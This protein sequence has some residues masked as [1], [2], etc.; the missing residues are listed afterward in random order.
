MKVTQEKLPASQIGLEIEISAEASQKAYEKIVKELARTTNLPGFR[1]GK[2]PRQVLI[3]RLGAQRVKA[4]ALEEIVQKSLEE[5]IEQESLEI[6]GNHQLRTSFEEL[7]ERYKPGEPLTFSASVDV[8][9]SL[10]LGEE[11]QNLSVKAEETTYDSAQVEDFIEQR[12]KEQ[13]TL[14]PVEER[15]AQMGD[16]VV[17]D[18]QGKYG[19]DVEGKEAGAEIPSTAAQDFQV[20]LEEGRFIPG[21]VEGIVGMTA[22]ESKDLNLTFPE[23]Y[24]QEE[25][26]GV[27][28]VFNIKLKEIKEKELPEID[29]DFAQEVSEFETMAELRESLESQFK[30]KAA[31]DTKN[32]IHQVIIEQLLEKLGEAIEI[33]ETM[34]Q[35]EVDAMLTQSAMQM[36]QMGID[37]RQ[38]FTKD[39]IPQMRERSRPEATNRLK[40]KLILREINKKEAIEVPQNEIDAKVKEIRE[41][42]QERDLDLARLKAMVV[43]DLRE[44][45]T[46]DWLQE[47]ANV[48]LVPKGS[49]KT[50]EAEETEQTAPETIETTAQEVSEPETPPSQQ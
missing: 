1:K 30:E 34:V 22:E 15:P 19:P 41:Q 24:P 48:E 17:V 27:A 8:S 21:M 29:D 5:A 38:L 31:K 7:L 45:K 4:A 40:Q 20:E 25:L 10:E 9:P 18:Y 50:D 43:E 37:F 3:Q 42:L 12:R 46:L 44:E 2:V 49:L 11:Y 28:V 35:E 36:Q 32:S 39:N 47:R 13:A 23:D 26:A 14:V 6:L 33:P 16:V